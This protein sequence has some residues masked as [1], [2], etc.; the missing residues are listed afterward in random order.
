MMGRAKARPLLGNLKIPE[1]DEKIIMATH[2]IKEV[3]S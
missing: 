3:K 1:T 2:F